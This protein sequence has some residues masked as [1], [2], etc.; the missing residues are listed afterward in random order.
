MN[1]QDIDLPILTYLSISMG[2]VVDL[3]DHT[4]VNI[5]Q[6]HLQ[7]LFITEVTE[8]QIHRSIRQAVVTT[9][10]A[11]IRTGRVPRLCKAPIY[12]EHRA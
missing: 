2:S 7:L 11:D 4:C 9:T 3:N 8:E 10:D 1:H 6:W 12:Q 5:L